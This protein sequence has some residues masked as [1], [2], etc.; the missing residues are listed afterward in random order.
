MTAAT[1]LAAI[2]LAAVAFIGWFIFT[3]YRLRQN[4]QQYVRLLADLDVPAHD[5]AHVNTQPSETSAD[6][7]PPTHNRSTR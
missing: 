2:V 5:P 7:L 6:Q 3:T 1:I 4:P